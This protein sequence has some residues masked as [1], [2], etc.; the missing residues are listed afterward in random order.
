MNF[1]ANSLSGYM[2]YSKIFRVGNDSK[3]MAGFSEWVESLLGY[4]A[5]RG[6]RL[7]MDTRSDLK[8][9]IFVRGQGGSEFAAA[10]VAPGSST[11]IRLYYKDRKRAS[12]VEMGRKDNFE[13]AFNKLSFTPSFG[14]TDKI[15]QFEQSPA[16]EGLC[17]IGLG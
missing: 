17:F 4:C 9:R 15:K 11:G 14:S 6:K 8:I 2:N 5:D 7:K 13:M 1:D 10:P 3:E 12:D 16:S